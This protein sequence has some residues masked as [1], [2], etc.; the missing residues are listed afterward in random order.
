MMPCW[1]FMYQ[2]FAEDI[3]YIQYNL[4]VSREEALEI[5][6]KRISTAGAEKSADTTGGVSRIVTTTG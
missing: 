4:G 1:G 3:S 5:W 6:R 2:D